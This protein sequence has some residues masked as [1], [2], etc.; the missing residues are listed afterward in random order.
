MEFSER[1]TTAGLGFLPVVQ[2]QAHESSA[3][4]SKASEGSQQ[5]G[6]QHGRTSTWTQ[7]ERESS[8]EKCSLHK[9]VK[10]QGVRDG[11]SGF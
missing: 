7:R 6:Q 9:Q 4:D 5:D 11:A 3:Q 8:S 1:G 10:T 2:P